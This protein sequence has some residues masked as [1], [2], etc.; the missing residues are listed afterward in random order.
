MDFVA[1]HDRTAADYQQ[2]WDDLVP[3]GYRP[4]SV[5]VYGEREDPRYAAVWVR[6]DGPAFAGIHGA[7]SASGQAFLETWGARGYQSTI[8]AVTGSR[9]D[10]VLALVVEH[11]DQPASI[12]RFGLNDGPPD[13]P[14]SLQHWLDQAGDNG[15][16]LRWMSA[17]GDPGDRAYAVVLD[18]EPA[19]E[20][21]SAAGC[22]GETPRSYQSRFD[23]QLQQWARPAFATVS[24]QG[25]VSSAFRI[26]HV[27]RWAAGHD[28]S[29]Q[30][31]QQTFDTHV[32]EGLMPVYVQAGGSG[33]ATR[34]AAMFAEHDRPVPR[35]FRV[36]GVEV[37]ALG[38]VD[39]RMQE[40]L[41]DTATR[42]AGVAV[43]RG[44]RLV[45]ARGYTWAEPTYPTVEPTTMFRVASCSK[46][47]TSIAVFQLVQA[48]RL[49]LTDRVQDL[50]GLV[51]PPGSTMDPRFGDITVQHLLTHT[52]GWDRSK[53]GDL[54]AAGTVAAAFG[55]AEL[56]VTSLQVASYMAGQPLQFAPGAEQ[57][58]SN[59]GFLLLGLIVERLRGR[60]YV[61]SVGET[62]FGRLGLSRP[63]LT[64]VLLRDQRPGAARQHDMGSGSGLRLG[65]TA[66]SG[67]AMAWFRDP[68]PLAYGADDIS[69]GAACGGWC[70]APADYA[71]VLAAFTFGLRNP[72]LHRSTVEAMWTVPSLYEHATDVELPNYANGWGSWTQADG[73][74]GFEHDGAMPGVSSRILYRT[75]GLGL[76]VFSNGAPVPDLYPLLAALPDD[77]WPGHDLFPVVGIPSLPGLE[78][79]QVAPHRDLLV[80]LRPHHLRDRV[81]E[82]RG[83]ALGSPLVT[84]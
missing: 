34:F 42:G 24:P 2:Q 32:G 7:D 64:P 66:V 11:T 41:R 65:S 81:V 46:P 27:G 72:L 21:W 51:P 55:Q 43:M 16:T 25:D 75:D 45:L 67:P 31:Y 82:Q 40:W 14:G 5:S 53:A 59:L 39:A 1:T 17:Y 4:I 35:T 23:A 71:K 20:P 69:V 50:L 56:P 79:A 12:S 58:Y 8:M 60:G 29:S 18:P 10:P 37:P 76:A 83:P 3:Q 9:A 33:D 54:P 44:G 62:V 52:G 22:R 6:R 70:L 26:D 77:A 48:G 38:A 19:H 57:E 80:D 36:T 78:L 28:M 47:I 15:W 74:R 84:H 63:H 13:D 49:A 68:A 73:V 61:E 30:Q